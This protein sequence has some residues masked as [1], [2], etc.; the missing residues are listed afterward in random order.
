M[1]DRLYKSIAA[2]LKE[3]RPCKVYVEDVPQNFAQPSFMITFHEQ[4]PTRGING[5]LKNT[6]GADIS[7]FPESGS[8]PFEE[9]WRVGEDLS[10]EFKA[11]DFK[12][13]N[14]NLKIV[15]NVLH[16][17]FELDYREYL[18]DE[19]PAMQTISQNTGIKEE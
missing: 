1:I 8:E 4:N 3:I 16:F 6:V 2:G 10:R 15:D 17:L 19:M 12:V 5:K 13:R 11:A 18:P 14:R 7:Y 9:C